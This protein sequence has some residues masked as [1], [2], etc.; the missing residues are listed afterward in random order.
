MI[1]NPVS[2]LDKFVQYILRL[3]DTE[4]MYLKPIDVLLMAGFMVGMFFFIKYSVKAFI[5][6]SYKG[7]KMAYRPM[8]ILYE[9][10]KKR[11]QNKKTCHICKNPLH[12]CT[13]PSNRGVSYRDRLA[14]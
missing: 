3:L 10:N 7:A 1:E 11:M 8:V 12:K 2:I 4:I 14:K 6:Y 9:K 5:K 13:C